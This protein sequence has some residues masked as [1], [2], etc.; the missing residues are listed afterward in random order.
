MQQFYCL[1]S[2]GKRNKRVIQSASTESVQEGI[3]GMPSWFQRYLL[4]GFIFQSTIIAGAYGSGAELAQFFLPYGPIGGLMGMAVTMI[5]FSIVLAASFELARKFSLFDYQSFTKKLLGPAALIYEILYLLLMILIISIIGA[6][7]GAILRDTFGLSEVFGTIGMMALIGV[8][9]FYGTSVVEKFLALWSFVLYGAYIVFLG[10][11]LVQYGGEISNNISTIPSNPGWFES[12]IAYAGYNIALAPVLLFCIRHIKKRR[13][14]VTAGLLGGPIAMIPA[15]LF[16]LAMIGQYDALIAA[17][18]DVLPVTLL[19]NALEGAGFF[20]YLFPIILFGTFI[21]TGTAMI[22]GVNE[23]IDNVYK[24]RG[25]HM[26]QWM[27]PAIA[28]AIL[29]VAIVLADAIGLTG[30][31]AQGYG[32]ITYGFLLVYVVPVMTYGIWLLKKGA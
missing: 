7:S 4:P 31:I 26:P 8:L 22:H 17:G 15:M 18:S 24:L 28:V 23:R 29:F 9:V 30:L 16:F 12:G 2:D 27:R 21:E 1:E 32:T 19:L 25:V 13:E 6:A 10:W 14:A 3:C 20:I 5:V 11:N